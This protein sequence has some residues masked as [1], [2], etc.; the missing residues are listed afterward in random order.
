M[1][2]IIFLLTMFLIMACVPYQTAVQAS[3]KEAAV[4]TQTITKETK[5][6]NAVIE[7]SQGNITIE[8]FPDQAPVT[9]ANFVGLAEGTKEF[10]D[11][12][13]G[14]KVRRKFYDGLTFHRVIP[15][16]M[17]QGGCPIGRG[18]GGPGYSFEDEIVPSLKFDKPGR[19][20]MANS[21]PNT[22]GSQFFIT[23]AATPWL[24]GNHTIFGQVIS[25]MDVV[26]KIARTEVDF[27]DNPVN[28]VVIKRITI[29]R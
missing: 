7:T 9:V 17:I 8:L 5:R 21:G 19:L 15:D 13:T 20:A 2:K 26:K 12:K 18:T 25:G 14:E 16:F 28:P 23:E 6:M 4:S 11:A 10:R 1:K 24:N 3:S 22:N 29:E 27:S